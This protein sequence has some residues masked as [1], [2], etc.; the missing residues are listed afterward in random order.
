MKEIVEKISSYN[1]LNN[2]FPGIIFAVI[3]SKIT[4]YNFIIPN[5]VLGVF[6]Y[7]FIGMIMSRIGSLLVENVLRRVRLIKFKPYRDYITASQYD[8]KIEILSETNNT[9]RT[10]I[11]TMITL[12]MVKLYNLL[13]EYLQL[14]IEVDFIVSATVIIIIFIIAYKKQV[15]FISKRIDAANKLN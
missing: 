12:I 10:I 2:L 3:A 5:D 13:S 7:Y 6:V 14:C 15:L 8:D 11:A 9:Y 1:I 4:T